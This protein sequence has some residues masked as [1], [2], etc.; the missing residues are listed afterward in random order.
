MI[1]AFATWVDFASVA[2]DPA[3]VGALPE[4]KVY[5]LPASVHGLSQLIDTPAS[6]FDALV[7]PVEAQLASAGALPVQVLVRVLPVFVQVVSAANL[8]GQLKKLEF[9]VVDTVIAV[10]PEFHFVKSSFP[11]LN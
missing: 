1:S 4:A 10:V 6:R 11:A 8:T 7:V 5:D 2:D 9:L 3:E